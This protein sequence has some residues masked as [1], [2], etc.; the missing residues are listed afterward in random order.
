L[1]HFTL[2]ATEIK[3]IKCP[4][5][6]IY[7]GELDRGTTIH[8][9]KYIHENIAN[10][11]SRFFPDKGHLI[12]FE[13][14]D[15]MIQTLIT[16]STSESENENKEEESKQPSQSNESTEENKSSEAILSMDE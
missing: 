14:W 3:D 8:M 10:S 15:E 1:H 16:A 13:I 5:V 11:K 9:A 7:H 4:N 6:T 2:T 12:Y